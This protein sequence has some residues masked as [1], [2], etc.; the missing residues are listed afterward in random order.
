MPSTPLVLFLVTALYPVSVGLLF[1]LIFAG[2][3]RFAGHVA[4]VVMELSRLCG[5]GR[6]AT[7]VRNEAGEFWP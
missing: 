4:W 5:Q 2:V 7:A 3:D 6:S 1:G